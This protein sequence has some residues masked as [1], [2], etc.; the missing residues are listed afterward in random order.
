MKPTPLGASPCPLR[1]SIALPLLLLLAMSPTAG[2]AR[3]PSTGESAE[4][5]DELDDDRTRDEEDRD[6]EDEEKETSDGASA[7]SP[8]RDGGT[9]RSEGA[10]LLDAN[11]GTTVDGSRSPGANP[12]GSADAKGAI[13]DETRS[14]IPGVIDTQSA[15]D[16]AGVAQPPTTPPPGIGRAAARDGG[17]A[18][19]ASG[20]DRAACHLA[21]SQIA[22]MGDSYLDLSGQITVALQQLAREAGA[23][24]PYETYIDRA[25]SGASMAYNPTIPAQLAP[26]L[27]TARERRSPGVKLVIMTGGGNDML[28]YNN[29]CLSVS[30][31]NPPCVAVVDQSV[32][33]LKKLFI[34]MAAA[35]IRDVI[36]FGYP[37]LPGGGIAGSRPHVMNGYAIPLLYEACETSQEV[38]CHFIDT[39]AT[40]EGHPEYISGADRVHPTLQGSRVIARLIWQEMQAEC[41]GST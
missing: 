18:L 13:D 36:Y 5:S 27:T 19:D 12:D 15:D 29:G 34:D 32:R 22:V 3:A 25:Q 2:C 6:E 30:Q 38:R 20:V 33:L 4:A 35:G 17:Q 8:L 40:F 9:T 7:R 31:P 10:R 24:G 28:I 1:S 14:T 41:L 21:G 26:V 39:R 16:A 37:N 11:L 23:L